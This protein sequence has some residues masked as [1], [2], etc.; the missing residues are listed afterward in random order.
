M[1]PVEL[2]VELEEVIR[3]PKVT[4]ERFRDG[5]TFGYAD[6]SGTTE[7]PKDDSLR[8]ASW[9]FSVVP[10]TAIRSISATASIYRKSLQW[11]SPRRWGIPDPALWRCDREA[12]SSVLAARI[13]YRSMHSRKRIVLIEAGKVTRWKRRSI[14]A[15]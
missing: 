3:N 7:T 5:N 2:L 8:I 12:S 15:A 13:L 9:K 10:E 11:R 6:H 4:P 1:L 14:R